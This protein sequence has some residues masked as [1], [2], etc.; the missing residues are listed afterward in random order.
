M[1]PLFI[2]WGTMG[3]GWGIG[4]KS[5]RKGGEG[6]REE[7]RK[8]GSGVGKRNRGCTGK[9]GKERKKN[10]EEGRGYWEGGE[11]GKERKWKGK[12]GKR[13]RKKMGEGV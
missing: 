6:K 1:N 4:C 13:E 2:I 11:W 5:R 3:E 10:R 12:W 9:W 8:R 7:I